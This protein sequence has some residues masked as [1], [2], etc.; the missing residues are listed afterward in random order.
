M[1]TYHNLTV[2]N[3]VDMF[4]R[5]AGSPSN[6]TIL[7]LHG[8]PSS[9]HQYR[10]LIP[11]LSDKYNVIA[12]DMPS[13]GFTTAPANYTYTFASLTETIAAFLTAL[14]ITTFSA[15]IFDYGAPVFFRLAIQNKFNITS[16]ISQN[17]N[18]YTVGFGQEF[19]APIMAY[20]R[21]GSEADRE[22]LRKNALTLSFTEYQYTAGT[23]ERDLDRIDPA[24]WTLDFVQ[25]TTR[26]GTADAQ[27]DLLYDYRT[28]VDLY[29]KFQ[30]WLRE[31]QPPLLAVWGKGD[32][33]FIPPGAKAFKDDVPKAEVHFVD[34][35]HFA[36]ETKGEEIG[37][38]V[39][40][41]LEK[42]VVH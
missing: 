39:N 30:E 9:S 14:E 33:A 17:G 28:N 22:N 13:Y 31:K 6:P 36:L 38:L 7:L 21:S 26:P 40:G 23:P 16:V 18:A 1:T 11:L 25:S 4:Y 27:L 2:A 29:P 8:F 12:P 20:W 32:P 42:N 5:R 10:N 3:G 19:W 15:Y 41:F 37:S 34:A 24:T 35:G